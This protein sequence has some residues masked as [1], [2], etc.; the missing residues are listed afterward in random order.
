MRTLK[1]KEKSWHY[2]LATTMG[3]FR[4][5]R[6]DFCSYVRNAIFGSVLFS[7]LLIIASAAL[8][9]IGRELYAFYT[10]T[11]TNVCTFGKLEQAVVTIEC[12]LVA[13]AAFIFAF[14]QFQNWRDKVEYEIDAGIRKR[15]EPGFVKMGYR[16]IKEK[17]CFRVEFK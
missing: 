1:F 5:G 12:I 14:I 2:F 8:Y 9:G 16:S 10:C 7:F 4:P 6:G 13:L 17:T 3:N 11:F 15:P